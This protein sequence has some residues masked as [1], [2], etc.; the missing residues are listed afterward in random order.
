[1]TINRSMNGFDESFNSTRLNKR[2]FPKPPPPAP[3]QNGVCVCVCV[4]VVVTTL[5]NSKR[6]RSVVRASR[7]S[8]KE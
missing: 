5:L 2:L 8:G 6:E 3:E 1:M 7:R 4:V